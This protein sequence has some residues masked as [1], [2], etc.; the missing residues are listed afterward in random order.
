MLQSLRFVPWSRWNLLPIATPARSI[1]FFFVWA[2]KGP[3]A[4]ELF[5]AR[6]MRPCEMCTKRRQHEHGWHS[7]FREL[8]THC[9]C[10]CV[11][12]GRILKGLL[13]LCIVQPCKSNSFGLSSSSSYDAL[14]VDG[15]VNRALCCSFLSML[16]F[17]LSLS[18]SFA[19]LI[20][21]FMPIQLCS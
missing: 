9:V 10:A 18:L 6:P 5:S 12:F 8:C 7:S 17:L 20:F 19:F 16:V 21:S 4:P 1:V 13:S 11:A 3:A 14:L 15:F 2:C